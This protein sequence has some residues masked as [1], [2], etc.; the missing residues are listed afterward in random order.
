[1]TRIKNSRPA[2]SYFTRP[3]VTGIPWSLK[4]NGKNKLI[5]A[6]PDRENQQIAQK[7]M[8]RY[9][10]IAFVQALATDVENM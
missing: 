2:R 1:M 7:E 5:I 6:I 4:I 9:Y 3:E 10:L 8:W